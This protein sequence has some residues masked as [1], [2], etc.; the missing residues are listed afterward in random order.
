MIGN[1]HSFHGKLAG[2]VAK[3]MRAA[4]AH[5]A[6]VLFEMANLRRGDA[7][8]PGDVVWRDYTKPGQHLLVDVSGTTVGRNGCIEKC[9]R[10]PGHAARLREKE[11][12]DDDKKSGDP[13][14]SRGHRL[15]PFVVEDGGRLG[16]HALAL[17]RELAEKGVGG[18]ELRTPETWGLQRPAQMVAYWIRRWMAHLSAFTHITLSSV[19]LEA[20]RS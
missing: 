18:G 13:V 19:L 11:K 17:L 5:K 1:C 14:V 10:I 7:T 6:D 9:A 8:R 4:G 15:V 2:Q 12:F 16:Q 20:V 3:I